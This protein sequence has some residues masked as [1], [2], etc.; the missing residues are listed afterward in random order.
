M[1]V[2]G[3]RLESGDSLPPSYVFTSR[4]STTPPSPNDWEAYV[5][6]AKE[7]GGI[8][9]NLGLVTFVLR[10]SRPTTVWDMRVI[11]SRKDEPLVGVLCESA[12]G[13]GLT[14]RTI[15]ADLDA[16]NHRGKARTELT[17]PNPE[18][19]LE[20]E[21]WRWPITIGPEDAEHFDIGA[22]GTYGHYFWHLEVDYSTEGS[23]RKTIRYPKSKDW[24]FSTTQKVTERL[25]VD[26]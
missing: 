20:D 11:V 16:T 21:T 25:A 22:F 18:N 4:P 13:G 15:S 24:S 3:L 23:G 6:W 7:N 10:G 9:A 26:Y 8:V 2:E 12:M 19:D 17:R 5:G 1:L 14:T